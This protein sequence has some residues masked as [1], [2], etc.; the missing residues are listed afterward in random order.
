MPKPVHF[1]DTLEGV[2]AINN[3]NNSC[4]M[5]LRKGA[6]TYLV[7]FFFQ[8]LLYAGIV[9]GAWILLVYLI[10]ITA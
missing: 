8:L 4:C 3:R 2:A 1:G 9:D 10:L 5:L 7:F 6:K